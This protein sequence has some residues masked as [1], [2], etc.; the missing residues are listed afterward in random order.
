MEWEG[1]NREGRGRG[2]GNEGKRRGVKGEGRGDMMP[3]RQF[4]VNLVACKTKLTKPSCEKGAW[5]AGRRRMDGVG[6][7]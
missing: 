7:R 4:W 6:G 1:E 3:H 5:R 2:E